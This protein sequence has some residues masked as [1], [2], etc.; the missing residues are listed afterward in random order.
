MKKLLVLLFLILFTTYITGCF[1]ESQGENKQETKQIQNN[2]GQTDR[3]KSEDEMK[4]SKS[5]N[6]ENLKKETNL[7]D[8][9]IKIK[10][11]DQELI[12]VMEDNPTTRDFLNMLPLTMSFKDFAGAEKISYPPSKLSTQDAPNGY[13]PKKGDITCYSPWGN[14]AVFYKDREY[15]SGLIHMGHIESS[16]K[17]LEEMN[18][19]FDAMVTIE[20]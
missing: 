16:I 9:R 15:A 3:E 20:K 14:L 2:L 6:N 12:A 17:A 4:V 13:T 18:G 19:D 8:T 5:D 1:K 7:K 10:I 11:K